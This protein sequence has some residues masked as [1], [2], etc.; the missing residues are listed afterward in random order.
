MF[1]PP[2]STCFDIV[3]IFCSCF[4]IVDIFCTCFDIVDIFC[5]CFDIVDIFCLEQIHFAQ[6]SAG[7]GKVSKLIIVCPECLTKAIVEFGIKCLICMA[8]I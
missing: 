3:D 8:V 4:D 7:F 1:F 2:I 6:L 5:T